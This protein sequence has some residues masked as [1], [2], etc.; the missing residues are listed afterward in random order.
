MH[1]APGYRWEDR[2]ALRDFVRDVAFGQLFAA[3]PD[4]PRVAQVPA[5]WADDTTL[6]FHVSRGNGIAR[7]LDGAPALYTVLGPNGYI[8]PD[9]YNQGPD[10]AP[11]WNYA[12]VELEGPCQRMDHDALVAH[13]DQ[14]AAEHEARL[15]KVPW[16]RA[17]M[18]PGAFET[19]LRGA[20][21]FTMDVTAW[22]GTLKLGQNKPAPAREGAADGSEAAGRRGIAQL[23][24]SL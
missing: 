13:I 16:T 23:M 17:K 15:D 21:G 11:T 6:A 20:V 14:L 18:T 1:P 19:I 10:E 12:A 22:R 7:H 3:T 9:W 4:G 24:R 2:A 8:S 5:V